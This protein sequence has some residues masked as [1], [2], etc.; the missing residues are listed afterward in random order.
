MSPLFLTDAPRF[1]F[2]TGKGGVGKTSLACATAVALADAGRRV[3][4]VSTDPASN[5]GQVFSVPLTNAATPI[6]DVPG[7]EALE[8]NPEAAAEAYREKII[9]PVRDLLPAAEIA[10]MTE[11]L[12]GSCTTE[13]AS[14]N[15]FTAL[16]ADPKSTATYDHVIFDTAP[17]GHTI[18]LLE[19]PGDWSSFI[20]TGKGDASCLGPMS[21][22]EKSRDAY[23]TAVTALA[24][25]QLTRLVLVARA[26]RS[27]LAEA[28]R[29]AT[30]LA[31]RGMQRQHLVVNA[32]LPAASTGGDPLADA[33]AATEQQALADLP[34]PLAGLPTDE[35][36]LQAGNV[37]GLPALRGLLAEPPLD[38]RVSGDDRGASGLDLPVGLDALVDE[39]ARADHGLVMCMGKGGVGKT[40]VAAA[41][42]VALAERGH[43]VH[44]STTD[45]AGRP[46]SIV[47]DPP[48]NLTVT[49]IDPDEAVAAYTERVMRTK[50]AK[51]DADGRA[52]LAEDLRSPCT[53][54][55]AVFQAFS[56]IINEAAKH[57]VV[58]DTAPTGHTLLLL[59]TTGSYHREVQRNMVA[60]QH[61]TTPMMRLQDPELTKL[62]LV[63]LPET[64]PVLEARQFEQDLARAGLHPWAWVVNQSL[65][66]ARTSSPL[67]QARAAAEVDHLRVVAERAPR[68]AVLPLLAAEP[69]GTERLHDLS[70]LSPRPSTVS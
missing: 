18:R 63:T 62:V 26:D 47:P 54:E 10:S 11:A 42:A 36:P 40:T 59:D 41:L 16:L 23:A 65:A 27:S 15:E 55:V 58:V 13:V 31:D 21:G 19:L 53:A 4:L 68:V 14:F 6:P 28:A 24:D 32:V 46:A 43:R 12:S 37:V 61:F 3:L 17:T 64:T 22:L 44:L 48:A 69:V 38:Q 51:L 45:P 1:L 67:L 30:E 57:F 20:D 29:A 25:P 2:F 52:Q 33:L 70:N 7:L 39:L 50:G 66:A 56:R 34:H 49:R 9:A 60:E 5:V 8:I 35:I